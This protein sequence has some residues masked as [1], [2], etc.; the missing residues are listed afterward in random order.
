MDE[1]RQ[2]TDTV[3]MVRPVRFGF[4]AETAASNVFQRRDD[5]RSPEAIQAAARAEHDGVVAALRDAG[6]T[7]ELETDTPDPATPDSIFPNNWFSTH[8]DGTFVLYPMA[9]PNRRAER[10]PDVVA[11][12]LARF[13][14]R[15]V[16]DLT[17]HEIDGRFLEGTGSLLIDHPRR[18]AYVCASVRADPAVVE[19][20]RRRMGFERCV[21]FHAT[22]PDD[23]GAPVPVYHTNV[24]MAL[25]ER[26][27]VVCA[28]AVDDAG[29]RRAL[30]GSLAASGRRVVEITRAQMNGFAGNLLQLAT[31][32]GGRIW[33]MSS[34]AH[35]ALSPA[36][37][38]ILAEDGR[39]VHAPIPTIERLGG[40]SVRCLLAEIFRPALG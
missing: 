36:E 19:A 29:E 15:T 8:E 30:V 4:N 20:W 5:E 31:A 13:G 9:T 37:R 22:A 7:V 18:T 26:T 40:G 2:V 6:V 17:R 12:L 3:L 28:E 23:G 38:A 35:E 34:A 21:T 32:G 24:V 25:G 33:A 16:L 1:R 11:R 39:L 27:C 14:H 10:R